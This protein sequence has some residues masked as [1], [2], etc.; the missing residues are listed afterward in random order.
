MRWAHPKKQI[1]WNVILSLK[2]VKANFYFPVFCVILRYIIMSREPEMEIT[3][4]RKFS[5]HLWA[6]SSLWPRK[7]LPK[8]FKS[9]RILL[10]LPIMNNIQQSHPLRRPTNH[11]LQTPNALKKTVTL[12]IH[13]V[14]L[15]TE[16]R[17]DIKFPRSLTVTELHLMLTNPLSD[18]STP[19]SKSRALNKNLLL[20]QQLPC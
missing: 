17:Q 11:S 8:H 12:H 7:T 4:L 1:I 16:R 9:Y 14:L 20:P 13:Y 2:N 19:H 15:E 18:W 3:F 5:T 10:Q 6:W